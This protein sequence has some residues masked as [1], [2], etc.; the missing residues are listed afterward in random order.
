MNK[1]FHVLLSSVVSLVVVAISPFGHVSAMQSVSMHHGITSGGSMTEHCAVLCQTSP[2]KKDDNFKNIPLEDDD[3]EPAPPYYLQ[4]DSVVNGFFV[5][6][7]AKPQC[8]FAP[9]K[10]PKYRLYC[11]IQR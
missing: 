11:V 1:L 10:V 8:V 3:D 2:V 7:D 6:K 5:E 9:E 4:F